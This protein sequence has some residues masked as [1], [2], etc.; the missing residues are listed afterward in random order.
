MAMKVPIFQGSGV[1]APAQQRRSL[2]VPVKV[3]NRGDAL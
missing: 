3:F 1:L 2:T